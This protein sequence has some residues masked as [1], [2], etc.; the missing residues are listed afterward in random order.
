MKKIKT[1]LISV[2]K[3]K[4]LSKLLKT[5]SKHKIQIISS[6]GTF[7]KI[8]KL[9]YKIWKRIHFLIYPA[10]I[11][12]SL[13]FYMLVRANKTEP[14]IYIMIVCCLLLYRIFKRIIFPYLV[15]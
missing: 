15:R 10:A 4:K 8:K 6:G 9:G 11:L 3:K 2:S 7:K 5:L 13:H 14:F 1:A 12:S